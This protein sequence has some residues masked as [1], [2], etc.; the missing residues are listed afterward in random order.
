MHTYEKLRRDDFG[1]ERST[2]AN[3][4]EAVLSNL[5][6]MFGSLIATHKQDFVQKIVTEQPEALW[7]ALDIL[8]ECR[9]AVASVEAVSVEHWKVVSLADTVLFSVLSLSTNAGSESDAAQQLLENVLEFLKKRQSTAGV[10]RARLTPTLAGPPLELSA[11]LVFLVIRLIRDL[12]RKK[13]FAELG[14]S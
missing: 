2:A 14:W 5:L 7:N 6:K 13:L 4:N 11:P 12:E 8:Y 1:V 3:K 10:S 9:S